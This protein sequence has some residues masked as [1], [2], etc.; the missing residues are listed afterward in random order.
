[1]RAKDLTG[2]R[3]SAPNSLSWLLAGG[4]SFSAQGP[5]HRAARDTASPRVSGPRVQEHQDR[6]EGS[7]QLNIRSNISL[8]PYTTGHT[9]QPWLSVGGIYSGCESQEVELV[10][11]SWRLDPMRAN[12]HGDAGAQRSARLIHNTCNSDSW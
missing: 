3:G 5:L 9:D 10:G 6:A 8:L 1:M 12:P 2:A 7:L 4:L 11:P